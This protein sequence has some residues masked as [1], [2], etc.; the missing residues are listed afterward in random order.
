[1]IKI[2]P[3]IAALLLV[4]CAA[5]PAGKLQDSDF[6]IRRFTINQTVQESLSNFYE[7][8]RY[9]GFETPHH[10]FLATHHGIPE[11]SPL[12]VDGSAVCD[13]Y[14]G[15]ANSGR[16]NYVLGR[17]EFV[18]TKDTKV[19]TV[20]L[21]VQNYFTNKENILGA[22]DKFIRGKTKEVCPES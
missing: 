2:I 5:T 9:C 16:T 15:T 22:W 7:S 21:K 14:M 12:R 20:T 17:V 18:P 6:D 1:M 8:L 11:C 10:I 19:T 3:A 4:G 13:L